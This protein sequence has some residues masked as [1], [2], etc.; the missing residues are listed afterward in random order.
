MRLSVIL[1]M[2]T[3]ADMYVKFIYIA[4]LPW[5]HATNDAEVQSSVGG[6]KNFIGRMR[7]G[8]GESLVSI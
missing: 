6:T 5:K 4:H 8:G 1:D 2:L 7:Y 3:A